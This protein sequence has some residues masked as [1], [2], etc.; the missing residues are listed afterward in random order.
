MDVSCGTWTTSRKMIYVLHGVRDCVEC[1][2][3]LILRRVIYW[4][5]YLTVPVFDELCRRFLNF[6]SC[7]HC[8][9]DLV[10]FSL[11]LVFSRHSWSRFREEMYVFV[12]LAL[13]CYQLML[14]CINR[15]KIALIKIS[16]LTCPWVLWIMLA[17]CMK[18]LLL[19]RVGLCW[20]VMTSLEKRR[21]KLF[22]SWL[23]DLLRVC[24]L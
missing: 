16:C 19:E 7:M 1:G 14:E 8:G 17:L 15:K 22:H 20:E 18:L 10:S 5:W 13:A 2:G 4:R 12:P 23:R 9:S 21:I 6:F 11:G 3:Y 24:W